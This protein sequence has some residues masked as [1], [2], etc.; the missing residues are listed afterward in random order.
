MSVRMYKMKRIFYAEAQRIAALREHFLGLSLLG[1]RPVLWNP[2]RI[3]NEARCFLQSQM[4]LSVAQR[5]DTEDLVAI[6]MQI[7][8]WEATLECLTCV[9]KNPADPS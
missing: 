8:R 6:A 4:K 2:Q 9:P 3:H 7:G 5:I 1:A